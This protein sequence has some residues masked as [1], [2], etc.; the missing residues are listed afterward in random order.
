[1]KKNMLWIALAAFVIPILARGLLFYRGFPNQPKIATP[2]YQALTIPQPV[3]GKTVSK[4]DIPQTRGVVLFDLTH[5]NQYQPA[6]VQSLQGTIEERGGRVETV[7]DS[8]SLEQQLKY[9][10]TLTIISPS[11]AF[12][13]D[14]SRIIQA[15]VKRGGRLL[16]FT[17]ATHGLVF[18]DFFTGSTISYPDTNLINPLLSPFGITVN[19]DYLYNVE[20]HEGNFRNIFFAGFGKNELTFGLKKV[21]LYGTHSIKTSSGLILFRGTESTLSSSD[22]AHHQ[23]EGG[24]ALNKDGNVL[25]FGDFTFLSSPYQNVLDNSILIANI[26]DFSLGSTQTLSLVN[27]PYIFTQ[28]EV[29]VYPLPEVQLTPETISAISGLQA[30]LGLLNISIMIVDEA[31]RD[32]DILALG[33]FTKSDD[34]P[35]F[36]KPF[37]IT[38]DEES[39]T[40]AVPGFGDVSRYGNGIVLFE[41]NNKGN[42]LTLL[43]NTPEDL[44]V[45]LSTVSSG[46]LGNCI[47]QEKIAVCSVGYGG[48][49][50]FEEETATPEPA[51]SDTTPTP[52]G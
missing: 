1:M 17:D 32:G 22:D 39:D 46:S 15:F 11:A 49:S 20:E 38:M 16:V 28:P 48:E 18:T 27:F 35:M 31:P 8:T 14:E 24:A 36:T 9:A 7:S 19:N 47:V 33:T 25:V 13:A 37:G 12:S 21:A 30:S 6:D 50:S 51:A 52:S 26:A 2:D 23:S 44:L 4:T 3:M 42:K 45:L 43:A 40:I 41:P 29:Q 5:A 10:S 34:L